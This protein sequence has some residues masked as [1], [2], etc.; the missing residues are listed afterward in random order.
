MDNKISKRMPA[1]VMYSGDAIL[2][3]AVRM[4]AKGT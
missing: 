2:Q 3:E 1:V 4:A